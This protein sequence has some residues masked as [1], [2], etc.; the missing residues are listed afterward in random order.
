MLNEKNKWDHDR[1]RA[2][3]AAGKGNPDADHAPTA[4]GNGKLKGWIKGCIEGIAFCGGLV[5][6]GTYAD[7]YGKDVGH[8]PQD[9]RQV[10]YI[11][12]AL[13]IGYGIWDL[14]QRYGKRRATPAPS[15][16]PAPQQPA[17]PRRSSGSLRDDN[18]VP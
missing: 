13:F 18:F 3:Y 5:R 6:L 10:L 2:K 17:P 12:V 1:E 11:L 4:P 8:W 7:K 16:A 9:A 14:Y 15:P